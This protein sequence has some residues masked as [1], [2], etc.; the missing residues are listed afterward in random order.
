M[1]YLV[2]TVGGNPDFGGYLSVDGE[3]SIKL[4]DDITYQ[5]VSG[6]HHFQ[7]YSRSDAQRRMGQSSSFV[8]SLFGSNGGLFDRFAD[9]AAD[10]A[11]GQSWSFQ[12]HVEDDEALIIEIVSKGDKILSAPQ[13]RIQPLDDETLEYL[14]GVFGE[15]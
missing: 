3:A 11:I 7:L 15:E 8:N 14:R 5:L 10:N 9:A 4:E 2:I 12:A 6:V 1:A 13:Y